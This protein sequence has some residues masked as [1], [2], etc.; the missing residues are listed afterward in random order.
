MQKLETY[1]AFIHHKTLKKLILGPFGPLGHKTFFLKNYWVL[2]QGFVLQHLHE[3]INE[4][5]FHR[6]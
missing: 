6:T 3:K 5:I 2:F 4:R 1:H